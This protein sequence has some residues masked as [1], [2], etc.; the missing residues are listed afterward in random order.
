MNKPRIKDYVFL[1]IIL[2]QLSF[3]SILSKFASEQDFLSL[4]FILLYGGVILNLGIYAI[5][6]QQILKR[7]PLTTAFCNKAVTIVWGLIFGM[8]IFKETVKPTMIIGAVIV[9]TGVVLVVSS[10]R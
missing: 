3:G 1:H 9:L 5:L 8:L 6:W 7:I 4:S 10:D 2:L